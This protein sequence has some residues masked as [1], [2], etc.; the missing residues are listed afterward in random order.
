MKKLVQDYKDYLDWIED[1]AKHLSK[2][3]QE[4]LETILSSQLT[5][6]VSLRKGS[7]LGERYIDTPFGRIKY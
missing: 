2:D 7:N 6:L 1:A 5:L 4:N 3:Q